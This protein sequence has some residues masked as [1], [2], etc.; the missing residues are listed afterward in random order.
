MKAPIRD[1]SHRPPQRPGK[2]PSLFSV[3]ALLLAA[4]CSSRAP[5]DPILVGHL[6]PRSGPDREVGKMQEQGIALAEAEIHPK[7]ERIAGRTLAVL[8]SDSRS[9]P[10]VLQTDAVRLLTVSRAAALLGGADAVQAEIL[11]RIAQQYSVPLI[12]LAGLPPSAVRPYVF[13][14]GIAPAEQGTA[15][16]RFAVQ[17][18]KAR[19]V[20]V[21]SDSRAAVSASVA[22]A[23]LKELRGRGASGDE[24]T[25]Q[26]AEELTALAKK[27]AAASP[28]AVVFVGTAEDFLSFRSALTANG[29]A[30][31]VP[32]LFGGEEDRIRT[33]AADRT[34]G[35]PVYL[36]T[37]FV[38]ADSRPQV[39][40]FVKAFEAR[41]G[42]SP[43]AYAALAYDSYRL[44][45][46]AMHRAQSTNGQ[47]V[48][49]EL[50]QTDRFEGLTGPLAFD[51]NQ[52]VRRTVFLVRL[53][54]GQMKLVQRYEPEG[55]RGT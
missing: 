13:S 39:K 5:L 40:E 9:D 34:G 6:A 37:S 35:N 25:Y 54:D 43:D 15:L 46:D 14:L 3:I 55:E 53:Q 4:G 30:P 49:E 10:R 48:R 20:A 23:V 38:V 29:L 11:G 52:A 21:V 41:F 42:R 45:F 19:R 18:L 2:V 36:A 16:A 47:R 28:E 50:A 32:L 17:Q 31:S 7:E 22:E 33:L 26:D 51:S 27:V 12:T 1:S 44:L 24:A 8:H